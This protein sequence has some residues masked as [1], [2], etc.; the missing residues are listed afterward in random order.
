MPHVFCRLCKGRLEAEPCFDLEGVPCSAQGLPRSDELEGEKGRD[1]RVYQC[2]DCGLVQL[3]SEPVPYFREVIT[4]AGW[5]EK[6][7]A[8]RRNQAREFVEGFRLQG[9]RV[10]EVG[11]GE[12]YFLDLL[13]ECGTLGIG[14]EAGTGAIARGREAGRLIIE[15]YLAAETRIAEGPFDAFV[16]INFLEHA[17]D[18]GG[19]LRAIHDNLVPGA[20]GLVEVPSFGYVLECNRF[21]D[22]IP[23]HLSYFTEATLRLALEGSGFEVLSCKRVWDGYDLAA[24]V[25]RRAPLDCREW[26]QARDGL[27]ASLREFLDRYSRSG[28][29]IAVWG[30]SHQALTLLSLAQASEVRYV[31]DSAPFKQG[32]FTPVVHTPIFGPNALLQDPVDAVLVM[33]AGY[34]DEVVRILRTDCGFAGAVAVLRGNTVEILP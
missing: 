21:Y 5:S 26:S 10:I 9:R 13:K 20:P 18:P 7:V 15:G 6:M 4:A 17:P 24:Q 3:T 30:A 19:M 14:L 27:V 16:T 32:R 33:A 31:V 12:G 23:D 2:R 25:R 1:L 8:F 28:G 11:C 29:K 22:F 34:S